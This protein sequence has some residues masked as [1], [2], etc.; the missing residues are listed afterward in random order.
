MTAFV[1]NLKTVV[2][3]GLMTGLLVA[4]GGMMGKQYIV[5]FLIMAGL[6]NVG[7]WFF[8]DKIAI[9]AM[10]GKQLTP[11]TGGDLYRMVDELRQR[12]GLPMP[13]VYLCPHAA[14]NAFA[15]GRSPRKA[16][17]AFTQGCVDMMNRDELAGIAAH[18]LTHVKNRD[19]LT[20]CV[21]ATIA[22]VLAAIA[23]WG[24]LLG[25]GR[26]RNSNPLV[27]LLVTIVAAVGAAM[28]KAAISRSREFVADAG[29]AQI[30]GSPDGLISALRKL[31]AT[32]RRIPLVQPNPAQNNLFIVEPLAN[33]ASGG[34]LVGLFATH[35]PT[36]RRIAALMQLR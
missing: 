20:S 23:Q 3:L 19:T 22:G 8:S 4:V 29:A 27:V 30:V 18:E 12:A 10:R 31:D 32:S 28:V 5:P 7:A 1:N 6:M 2:L 14:P 9:A 36:E 11:E 25:L 34:G 15:T 21:A 33:A 35:P 26:D 17:V 24:F 13:K 16:A